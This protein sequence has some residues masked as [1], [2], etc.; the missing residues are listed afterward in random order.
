MIYRSKWPVLLFPRHC[1]LRT[2]LAEMKCAPTVNARR[3]LILL[4]EVI[5]VIR[6]G[7]LVTSAQNI[8]SRGHKLGGEHAQPL[9]GQRPFTFFYVP[10]FLYPPAV[11]QETHIS[12]FG[13]VVCLR[14]V[15][16][17]LQIGSFDGPYFSLFPFSILPFMFTV[18]TSQSLPSSY[19]AG[20]CPLLFKT[21]ASLF[22]LF[23]G[24]FL[25]QP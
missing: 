17:P 8:L 7:R 6:P 24:T 3:A 23:S 1:L 15:V 21:S 9:Q 12:C 22:H 11:R 19:K 25:Y 13:I 4:A 20:K 10:Y 16:H 5:L 14:Y 18:P 2:S